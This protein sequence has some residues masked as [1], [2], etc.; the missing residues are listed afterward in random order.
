MLKEFSILLTS[1]RLNKVRVTRY[2]AP[3]PIHSTEPGITLPR[4]PPLQFPANAEQNIANPEQPNSTFAPGNHAPG[5]QGPKTPSQMP[6]GLIPGLLLCWHFRANTPVQPLS[7]FG[8]NCEKPQSV[9]PGRSLQVSQ[10][11]SGRASDPHQ[12][13]LAGMKALHTEIQASRR[14]SMKAIRG[15]SVTIEQVNKR[16][17]LRLDR[18]ERLYYQPVQNPQNPTT[19]TTGHG[20]PH[21]GAFN[22]HPNNPTPASIARDPRLAPLPQPWGPGQPWRD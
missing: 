1:K 7:W 9:P 6:V 4:H 21:A 18:L 19:H 2:I 5:H 15:L 12:T 11:K 14:D 16:L 8:L 13:L 22:Q 10:A 3:C 17:L 20:Q